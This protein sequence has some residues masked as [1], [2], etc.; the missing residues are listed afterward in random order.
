[1][2]S[3][4]EANQNGR[5]I[6][7]RLLLKTYPVA[8]K[9]LAELADIPDG[10]IRPRNDLGYELALCQGFALS[11]RQGKMVAMLK[12]DNWCYGPVI[13]FGLAEPPDNYWQGDFH[14]P[15]RTK[16]KEAALR[17]I[18]S[19]VRLEVGK[20]VGIVSAP[21]MTAN[22]QPDFV[23]TYCNS[24]QLG[25]MLSSLK[26]IDGLDVTSTLSPGGAC[27]NAVAPVVLNN[28]CQVTIP[29][30]GDRRLAMAHDDEMIMTIPA[31]RLDD[32]IEG[33][34]YL[35]TFGSLFPIKYE[36]KPEYP[37]SDNYLKLGKILGMNVHE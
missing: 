5:E 4:E 28:K 12:E 33:L 23:M 7:E 20:Y 30:A 32:L 37:L 31:E 1:M 34:R 21:L 17:L 26:Y 14:Y 19:L 9:M 22:F 16:T 36:M 8:L 27:F 24:A 35:D 29:C 3:L 15:L 11:R 2:P 25:R 6:R 18:N 13:A 10:A